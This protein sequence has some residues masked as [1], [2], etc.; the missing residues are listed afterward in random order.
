MQLR[1][2]QKN[3][4]DFI[5]GHFSKNGLFDKNI[6]LQSPTG[7]GKTL[8]MLS[9]VKDYMAKHKDSKIFISTGFNELVYQFYE[10]A[11]KMG[12]KTYILIGR[13]NCVCYAKTNEFSEQAFIKDLEKKYRCG[14]TANCA[15]CR[16]LYS[17]ECSYN[18]NIK[19]IINGFG[20]KLVITNHSTLLFNKKVFSDFD[21]GF[22]DECQSFGDFYESFLSINI[23][24]YRIRQ[25][26]NFVREKQVEDNSLELSIIEHQMATGTITKKS[27]GNLL[28]IE[29]YGKS[30]TICRASSI[31]NRVSENYDKLKLLKSGDDNYFHPQIEDG[32]FIGIKVDRFFDKVNGIFDKHNKKVCIVSATV[33]EYTKNIFEC[34]DNY[35]EK[36]Y[37]SIDYEKSTFEIANDLNDNAVAEFIS[38]QTAEHGLFLSTRLD[39]V[40]Y[41]KSKNICGYEFITKREHFKDGKKQILIGSKSLFQGINIGSIGFVILNKLPF[42]RYDESYK[43]KMRYFDGLGKSSYTYYTTPYTT[44]QLIQ[45]MGRLWRNAGDYGNI[46]MFNN[47]DNHAKIVNDAISERNGIVVKRSK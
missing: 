29:V 2:Y 36:S 46:I 35:V 6:S 16:S 25:I 1:D 40:D 11:I 22:I 10:D 20:P 3:Q 26:V 45:C 41:Y 43:K 34:K 17:V 12:I 15:T 38:K 27:L 7:S 13:Q 24:P 33:D 30:D 14:N 21:G 8:V 23:E 42:P 39:I 18:Y 32:K 47:N 9:A 31:F 28:D 44:N 37:N 19:E 4:L 5:E